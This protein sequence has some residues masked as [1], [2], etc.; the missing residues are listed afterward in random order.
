M[1]KHTIYLF[2]DTNLF[3]QCRPLE[4][5]DWSEWVEF[6]EVHLIVCRPVQREID[7]QKNRGND[8]VGQRARKTYHMF[9]EILSTPDRRL[10]IR[11]ADPCVKLYFCAPSLPSQELKDRLDYN[12]PDDELIGHLHGF[13]QAHPDEDVHLLSYDTGPMMTADSLGLPYSPISDAWVLQPENNVEAREIARLKG[14]IDQLKKLEPNFQIRCLDGK[15][16]EIDALEVECHVYSPLGIQEMEE[17]IELL[18]TRFPIKTGLNDQGRPSRPTTIDFNAARPNLFASLFPAILSPSDNEISD[19]KNREY[20]N[21]VNTCKRVLSNL[22]KALQLQLGQPR[23]HFAIENLGTRPGRDAL[24]EFIAR[25]NFKL[26]PPH[27]HF[28]DWYAEKEGISLCI[29][30][31]PRPPRGRT[32]QDG[33]ANIARVLDYPRVGPSS[34]RPLPEFQHDP[35]AFYYKPKLPLVPADSISLGC[36]QWRHGLGN[37]DFIVGIT[38]DPDFHEVTGQP[39]NVSSRLKTFPVQ[40]GKVFV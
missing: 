15:E 17:L 16:R 18:K 26:S 24:V 6:E 10:L 34:V 36:D 21:W 8:R 12:K 9:R 35:N 7:N 37:K 23:V 22:H 28:P 4:E 31:P 25:G 33:L 19:Y 32:F 3:I 20:P 40:S 39:L 5:L 11:E 14:E 13:K 2:P 30:R 38:G 29:P 1:A 27:E